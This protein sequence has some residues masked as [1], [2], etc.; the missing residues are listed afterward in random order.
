M[1]PGT[2]TSP[3]GIHRML[4]GVS[5]F[6]T[7]ERTYSSHFIAMHRKHV[8]KSAQEKKDTGS[9]EPVPSEHQAQG[10]DGTWSKNAETRQFCSLPARDSQILYFA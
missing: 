8:A 2:I 5:D 1:S 3:E 7:S 10:G 6:F 9:P 4:G